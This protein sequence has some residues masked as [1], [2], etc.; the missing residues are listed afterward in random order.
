MIIFE[1]I[2]TTFELSVIIWGNWTNS[3]NQREL[4]IKP[5]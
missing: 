2:L 5:S 3:E 4:K 1:S